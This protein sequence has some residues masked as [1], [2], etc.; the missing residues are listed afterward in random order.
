MARACIIG[1]FIGSPLSLDE[2]V[3]G[4]RRDT[5]NTQEGALDT[6]PSQERTR[7]VSE[8]VVCSFTC[9]VCVVVSSGRSLASHTRD[10]SLR[11]PPGV[12]RVCA[13]LLVNLTRARSAAA[14]GHGQALQY[15]HVRG[16]REDR[17][18][19]GPPRNGRLGYLAPFVLYRVLIKPR[20]GIHGHLFPLVIPHQRGVGLEIKVPSLLVP[21]GNLPHFVFHLTAQLFVIHRSE[22]VAAD[23]RAP[24]EREGPAGHQPLL[25]AARQLDVGHLQDLANQSQKYTDE[26]APFLADRAPSCQLLCFCCVS[27]PPLSSPLQDSV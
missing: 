20:A 7:E 9:D 24:V 21:F 15:I 17:V 3:C 4:K 19:R 26:D 13:V 14:L 11:W 23:G 6:E 1:F 2:E 10:V 18:R 25:H 22:E 8:G 12:E 16:L 27:V 5:V